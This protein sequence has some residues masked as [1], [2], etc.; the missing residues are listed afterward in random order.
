MT[1]AVALRRLVASTHG[2]AMSGWIEACTF[3]DGSRMRYEIVAQGGSGAVR[4][5][6]LIAALDGEVNA[7][8]K[9]HIERAGLIPDN[10]E[11][12]PDSGT[13]HLLRVTLKPK[14]KDSM[15]IEGTMTLERATGDLLRV[16]GR[17]VKSPSLWTRQVHVTRRYARLGGVRVPV[18]M[19]SD[20]KVLLVGASTFEM[21]YHYLTINGR[22]AEDPAGREAART[23]VAP[24]ATAAA[25]PGRAA[26]HHDRGVALHLRRALDDA[27]GEYAAALENDPPRDPTPAERGLVERLAPRVFVTRSEP[28]ALRDVAAI[29][30]PDRPLIAYHLFW[31]DDIDFPDDNDPCDHEIVW[32]Q[33]RRDGSLDRLWTYFHGRILDGGAAAA[34]D[35][36]AHA[37]RPAVFV[38]WGKHGSMPVGWQ[39]H[40]IETDAADV[41][42]GLATAATSMTVGEYNRA[43]FHTLSTTG[44]RMAEHP[45]ARL[46]GWPRRFSGTWNDFSGFDRA[47]D[48]LRL[49]RGR[50]M[51]LVSRWNSA[52]INQRFLRYNFKP[53]SE[54]P[55][56][57]F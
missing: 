22:S 19:Q 36:A 21:S 16:E 41:E 8:R 50:R 32:V 24:G 17:L 23:C 12:V 42:A 33:Y 45:L 27:S 39:D 47:T 26:A 10:Y 43:A 29:V 56:E 25:K 14:R 15:L 5:R 38:Q 6:A 18:S 11:F 46:G 31:D 3:I 48:A 28:F 30:H 7:R 20:A 55:A 37:M 13:G 44:A 40:Q 4:K 51:I 2:G 57:G 53:K 52:T 1:S 9:G 34:A 35:A 54:W 49:L